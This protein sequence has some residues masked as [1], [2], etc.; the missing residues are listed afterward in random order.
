L[1]GAHADVACAECHK[2]IQTPNGTYVEYKFND[3]Q[4]SRCHQ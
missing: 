2:L 1:D 3:I 4:C